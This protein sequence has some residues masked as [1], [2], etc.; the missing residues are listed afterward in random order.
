MESQSA[1]SVVSCPTLRPSPYLTRNWW[2]PSKIAIALPSEGF[3]EVCCG[4]SC[5]Y[6]VN[7]YIYTLCNWSKR[8]GIYQKKPKLETLHDE[9]YT[10]QLLIYV[11][12]CHSCVLF[13]RHRR[14]TSAIT[15]S[16]G[17]QVC[18][19]ASKQMQRHQEKSTF[20]KADPI[21][22]TPAFA[23]CLP[24]SIILTKLYIV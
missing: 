3:K 4:S 13:W 18:F 17:L 23:E 6:T 21:T 14:K 15:L 19:P 22:A 7:I 20:E 5:V 8:K 10:Y 16:K 2:F 24:C 9:K 11:S 12:Q 1:L